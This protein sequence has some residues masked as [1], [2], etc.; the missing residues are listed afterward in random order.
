MNLRCNSC[1]S[2]GLF[3]R[4]AILLFSLLVLVA[5]S[6]AQTQAAMN[7]QARADFAQADADLNKTY[8]AALAKLRDAESKQKLRETQRAWIAP[9][10]AE[11]ARAAGEAHGADN[12]LR[13]DDASDSRAH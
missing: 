6:H 7:A 13:N 2:H 4:R 1:Q 8:Q 9:R 11:A 10:D 3:A 5:H 12:S